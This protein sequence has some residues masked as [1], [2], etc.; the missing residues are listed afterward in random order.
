MNNEYTLFQSRQ[1]LIVIAFRRFSIPC[2]T[3]HP[4]LDSGQSYSA[5]LVILL[6]KNRRFTHAKPPLFHRKAL[7]FYRKAPLFTV[8][9]VQMVQH[10]S[11]THA[12]AN[13]I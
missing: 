3:R 4:E 2:L 7:V 5:T 9:W 13:I 11:H 6:I 1:S 8:K 10:P 12:R